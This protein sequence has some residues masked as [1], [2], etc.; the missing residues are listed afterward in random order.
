MRVGQGKNAQET[1]KKN[2][3][4]I[5]NLKQ[6]LSKPTIVEAQ[7]TLSIITKLIDRITL[8][9]SLDSDFVLKFNEIK[10]PQKQIK[11]NKTLV[12]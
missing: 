8:F 9:I 6:T 7:R 5:N 4:I 1:K 12:Q 10:N 11:L 2:I 3:E